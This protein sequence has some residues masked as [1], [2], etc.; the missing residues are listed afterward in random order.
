MPCNFFLIVGYDV[1]D[2]KTSSRQ[3]FSGVVSEEGKHP[4][5]LR[6]GLSLSKPVLLGCELHKCISVSS[7]P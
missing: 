4:I 1:L 7:R 6:L 5:V 2:E 3:A